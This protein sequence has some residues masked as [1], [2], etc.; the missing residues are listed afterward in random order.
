VVIKVDEMFREAA[1][2]PEAVNILSD[3]YER[4][5]K[6]LHDRGQPDIVTEIIARNIILLAQ[7]GERDPTKLC[8]GAL[9]ALGSKAE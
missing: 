1:F 5:R 4:A 9:K 6:S 3:A 7:M 8:E 2:D